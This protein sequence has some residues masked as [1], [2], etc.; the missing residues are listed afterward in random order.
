MRLFVPELGK[1]ETVAPAFNSKRKRKKLTAIVRVHV[2]VVVLVCW[3]SLTASGYQRMPRADKINW[4]TDCFTYPH[5]YWTRIQS[6]QLGLQVVTSSSLVSIDWFLRT[7]GRVSSWMPSKPLLDFRCL[8]SIQKTGKFRS[9][10]WL[11]IQL[12]I[13]R[14]SCLPW[15]KVSRE[16]HFSDNFESF[17]FRKYKPTL[18]GVTWVFITLTTTK[19]VYV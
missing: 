2:A 13:V 14:R 17:L 4:Q 6:W 16:L 12:Q 18:F 3:S 11:F 10:S 7:T 1:A 5:D 19:I 9:F 8:V 15:P